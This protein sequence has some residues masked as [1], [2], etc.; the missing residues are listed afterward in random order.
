MQ[1]RIAIIATAVAAAIIPYVANAGLGEPESSA[2]AD[3]A[4]LHGSSKS[5]DIK[6][7]D[8]SNYRVHSIE[9]PSGTVVREYATLS[10]TVF[11]VAWSGP[12]V[13]NL[14]QTLGSYYATFLSGA[15]ASRTGHHHLEIRRDNFVMQSS[16]HM[17][18]FTGR[19][20]VPQAIPAGVSLDELH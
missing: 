13:P 10:G 5:T 11:A 4:V 3:A 16:G 9:L 15:K 1:L 7:T 14:Q 8:M 6:S 20:Y 12:A 17:R 19:A 2:S 18:A